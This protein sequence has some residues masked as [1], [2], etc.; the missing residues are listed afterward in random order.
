MTARPVASVRSGGGAGE[1]ASS[2]PLS[3]LLPCGRIRP[4]TAASAGGD[5]PLL[6]ALAAEASTEAVGWA[7]VGLPQMGALAAEAAGLDLASGVRIDDPG[8]QWAQVLAT[9]REAVP[10]VLV[11]P[12]GTRP[13]R[14]AAGRRTAAQRNGPAGRRPVAG[15]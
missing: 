15:G 13:D 14:A 1:S 12:S 7:A 4:G 11:G 5:M 8:R 3:A 9:R 6:L 2:S 10:V